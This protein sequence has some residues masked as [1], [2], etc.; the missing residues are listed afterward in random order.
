MERFIERIIQYVEASD[1]IENVP[2]V[3]CGVK[4]VD[5]TYLF[6]KFTGRYYLANVT[7]GYNL[8]TISWTL[9]NPVKFFKEMFD[10]YKLKDV[11]DSIST[12]LYI[13]L[14]KSLVQE[15]RRSVSKRI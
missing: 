14:N 1:E 6:K 5:T 11:T 7:G 3:L 15:R 8:A 9:V 13:D 4:I 12:D 10:V 2:A